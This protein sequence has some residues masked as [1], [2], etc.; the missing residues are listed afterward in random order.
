MKKKLVRTIRT[1]VVALVVLVI[2]GIVGAVLLANA[3]VETAV[4][5]A[6]VKTLNV[7]VEVQKA[8]VSL[9]SGS[10]RLHKIVVANPVGYQGPSLLTVQ[11][12]DVAV[13]R[14]L[15]LGDGIVFYNVHLAGMEVFIE[16]S[17][18]RNNLYEVIE[19][20]R[21]P[22]EPTGKALVIDKLTIGDIVVHVALPSGAGPSQTQVMDLKIAP[23]TMTDVGRNERMD[24]RALISKILLAV[25][26]AVAD[27]GTGI[28]PKET[29]DEIT[30]VLDKAIDIGRIIFGG[31]KEQ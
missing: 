31:K 16:Q 11:S 18:L 29:V 25:A 26:A 12:V 23:I 21:R 7:G 2:V 27:Q 20:L 13:G 24:T 28:L 10:G 19:P 6:G 1:T 3:V 9:L 4:E 17:G 8:R 30:G 15:L 5:K 22:H 14:G